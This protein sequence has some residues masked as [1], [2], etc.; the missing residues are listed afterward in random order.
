MATL[1]P[2]I[3]GSSETD[4]KQLQKVQ[5]RNRFIAR[6]LLTALTAFVVLI[7]VFPIFYWFRLSITPYRYVFSLPPRLDF[8]EVTPAWWRVI[9]GQAS[10]Q[11]TMRE[12]TGTALA[13]G[14]G[15]GGTTGYTMLGPIAHSVFYGLISTSIV[16]VVASV[17]AYALS[18]FDSR[19]KQNIVFFIISTRFMPPAA[20][21]LPLFWLY[22]NLG[23][24]ST[25]HGIILAHVVI[26]LPLSVLLIKS[27]FDDVP[28][29]LDDA[30]MVDGCTRFGA[31]W[32]IV[33]RYVLPG[34][35][36]AAVL[37][38]IFSWNEFILTLYLSRLPEMQTVPVRMQTYD[39]SAGPTEWG[40]LSS[41]GTAAMIPVFLF[42]LFVQRYLIRGLTLGALKG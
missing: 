32:R 42:I 26:N 10:Y 24:I 13:S 33:I 2:S 29:E 41:A 20:V 36:A 12:Q 21:V 8:P 4:W 7:F 17:T 14:V 37:C 25:Y 11:D 27:F 3:Q 30:A 9:L 40:L 31:F 15:G 34:I 5:H 16:I 39:T 1:S 38:F 18:R 28:R 35:A 19:G 6:L 22:T 23:M